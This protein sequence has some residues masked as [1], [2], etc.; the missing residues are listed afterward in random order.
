VQGQH[1]QN[2]AGEVGRTVEHSEAA[3]T[4]PQEK[5][6]QLSARG[7]EKEKQRLQVQAQ[8]YA[9]AAQD[10]QHERQV[11]PL[12]WTVPRADVAG[13]LRMTCTAVDLTCEMG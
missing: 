9:T 8:A 2:A 1:L 3:K 10:A 6:Q 4:E 11:Q 7:R 12:A 13:T 5:R